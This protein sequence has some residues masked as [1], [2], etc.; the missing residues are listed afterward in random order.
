MELNPI[1]HQLVADNLPQDL[2]ELLRKTGSTTSEQLVYEAP[3]SS[4]AESID[5]SLPFIDRKFRGVT[6][7][8]LACQ[9]CRYEC[10]EVLL[11]HGASCYEASDIGFRPFQDANG[12]GDR[13]LMRLLFTVRHEQLQEQWAKREAQLHQVLCLVLP[14]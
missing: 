10:T 11:K 13:D 14:C 8:G 5:S 6:A 7:L 1:L 4:A 12:F 9:L 2:D 3:P